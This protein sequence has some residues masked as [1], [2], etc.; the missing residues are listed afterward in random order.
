MKEKID[1]ALT[2][3]YI[4]KSKGLEIDTEA[5]E[6]GVGILELIR[7]GLLNLERELPIPSEIQPS[8]IPRI[9]K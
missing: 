2:R 9:Q 5:I 8:V 6:K 1:S 3:T 7:E 4:E